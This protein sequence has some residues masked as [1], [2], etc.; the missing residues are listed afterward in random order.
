MLRT[1]DVYE[2]ILR[3]H[4]LFSSN[5]MASMENINQSAR[6][7]NLACGDSIEVNICNSH[8]IVKNICYSGHFCAVAKSS[9]SLMTEELKGKSTDDAKQLFMNVQEIIASEGK[10]YNDLFH[11]L[12]NQLSTV[13]TNKY[14]NDTTT[15]MLLPWKTMWNA[16]NDKKPKSSATERDY[17]LYLY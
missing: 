2:E 4:M 17:S 8:N 7:T 15:C 3:N 14:R 11:N 13:T 9:A 1:D 12:I 16:L 5:Y 6:G 10:E